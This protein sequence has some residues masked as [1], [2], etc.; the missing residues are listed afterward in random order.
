MWHRETG[1][2]AAAELHT[3]FN[4]RPIALTAKEGLALI[5]GAFVSDDILFF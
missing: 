2:V 3:R 5:N 4:L 1:V